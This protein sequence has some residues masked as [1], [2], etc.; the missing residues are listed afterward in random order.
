[1]RILGILI[2]P[3]FLTAC[4]VSLIGKASPPPPFLMNLTPVAQSTPQASQSRPV[5]TANVV[6]IS[7]PTTP[8]AIALNR[9][10]VTRGG[11]AVAYL[12]GASWVEQP[13]RL[14]QRLLSET[15]RAQTGKHVLELRQF[16]GDPGLHV[17][18]QL[19][20]MDV[21]EPT[22]QVVVTYEATAVSA[23]KKVK[24]RRF[25]AR[26]P[27]AAIV[28]SDVAVALNQAANKVA[29]DVTQWIAE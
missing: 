29:Q 14:F 10:P 11:S 6:V 27:V 28:A 5:T 12:T 7:I 20:H 21:D 26:E 22:K 13:A 9:V 15:V 1:M 2:A 16:P 3:M 18:G 25:E 24:S 8:Q 17:S 19:L 23:D 4:S